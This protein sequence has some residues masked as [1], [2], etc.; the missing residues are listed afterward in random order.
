VNGNLGF[1]QAC[2]DRLARRQPVARP[3]SYRKTKPQISA[4]GFY[5]IPIGD[6]IELES[7]R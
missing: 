5:G 6:E 7:M 1:H 3:P 2:G 4:T